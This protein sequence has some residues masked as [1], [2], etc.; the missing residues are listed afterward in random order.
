MIKLFKGN[1]AMTIFVFMVFQHNLSSTIPAAVIIFIL[2]DYTAN[3]IFQDM[4]MSKEKS[5]IL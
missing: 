3:I 5:E 2:S 1:I 4:C